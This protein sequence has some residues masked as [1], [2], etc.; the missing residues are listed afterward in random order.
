MQRKTLSERLT[1]KYQ[2]IIRSE[3]NF[4][5]KWTINITVAK[6][7]AF[8]FFGCVGFYFFFLF[9]HSII[10]FL[11]GEDGRKENERKLLLLSMR[12]DSLEQAI[13]EKNTF[14]NSFKILLEGG[15]GLRNDTSGKKALKAGS[16]EAQTEEIN[17]RKKNGERTFFNT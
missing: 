4:A 9:I 3:E 16:A 14:I 5:E 17:F 2:L 12:I 13:H 10:S 15:V 8:V 11:A 7:I 6:A 1:D